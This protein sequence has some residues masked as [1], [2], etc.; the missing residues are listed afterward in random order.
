MA[1]VLATVTTCWNT[2]GE[3]LAAKDCLPNFGPKKI[4]WIN[5]TMEEMC[6]N[7]KGNF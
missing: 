6:V 5:E 4:M 3:M 1:R 2:S 7:K